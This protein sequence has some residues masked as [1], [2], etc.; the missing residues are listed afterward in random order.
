M[1][2]G[3]E[4]EEVKKRL[5]CQT[6]ERANIFPHSCCNIIFH[7]K[8]TLFRLI[9]NNSVASCACGYFLKQEATAPFAQNNLIG[10]CHS[11]F[12]SRL[13]YP[14]TSRTGHGHTT[15]GC[16]SVWA[17]GKVHGAGWTHF[18]LL[19]CHCFVTRGSALG[20]HGFQN[21]LAAWKHSCCS[22]SKVLSGPALCCALTLTGDRGL[23]AKIPVMCLEGTGGASQVEVPAVVL[24]HHLF[25]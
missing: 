11:D 23:L 21:C 2:S 1:C 24:V 14:A 13:P 12:R 3:K 10:T 19:Y 17:V 22:V 9:F 5:L 6:E 7:F 25:L 20:A 15:S 16:G 8:T 18:N 4:E